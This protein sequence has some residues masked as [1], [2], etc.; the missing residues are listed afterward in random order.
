[1][2]RVAGGQGIDTT[3]EPCRTDFFFLG[4]AVA[5]GTQNV[6]VNR[7]NNT[8]IMY[9]VCATVTATGNTTYAGVTAAN[10]DQA[11]AEVN[12]DDGSPGRGASLRY[13][14]VFSGLASPPTAGANSTLLQSIDFGAN[15]CAF[16]CETVAGNGSRPVG[17]SGTSDDVAAVYAAIIE[18]ASQS[19]APRSMHQYR[20]RRI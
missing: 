9:A 13:G 1:M 18:A 17:F 16:V 4:T 19:Q 10:N 12:I 3:T 5:T 15:G 20:L 11:L 14:A 2:E 6:V 7:T 8:T